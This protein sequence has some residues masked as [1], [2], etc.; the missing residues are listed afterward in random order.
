MATRAVEK[1]IGR[2]VAALGLDPN[3]TVHSPRVKA[4]WPASSATAVARPTVGAGNPGNPVSVHHS[5]PII[6]EA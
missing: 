4:R 1:L 3:V 6:V 2:S 5:S